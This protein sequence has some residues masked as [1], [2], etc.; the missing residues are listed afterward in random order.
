MLEEAKQCPL[1]SLHDSNSPVVSSSVNCYITT[2]LTPRIKREKKAFSYAWHATVKTLQLV[3]LVSIISMFAAGTVRSALPTTSRTPLYSNQTKDGT[4]H[5]LSRTETHAK[6]CEDTVASLT[7]DFEYNVTD[8][9]A[10]R[11]QWALYDD[12]QFDPERNFRGEIIF[13]RGDVRQTSDIEVHVIISSTQENVLQNVLLNSTKNALSLD[14][15]YPEEDDHCTDLQILVLFRPWPKRLLDVLKVRSEILDIS[16]HGSLSWEVNH[17][18]VHTSHGD[19]D[20][21]GVRSPDPLI[22]HNVSVSTGTGTVFA[23]FIADGHLEVHGESGFVGFFL[24]PRYSW[25]KRPFNPES[26]SVSTVSGNIH[27]EAGFDYWPPH[28]L[29]HTTNIHTLS[30]DVYAYI[31]H[32]SFTNITSVTSSIATY[33]KP[34]GAARSDDRSEIYTSSQSGARTYVYLVDADPESLEG[35]YDPL[36]N[37]TSEH[38]VGEGKLELRYPFSWFGEME[39]QIEHGPLYFDASALEHIERGE[40]YVKAKRGKG[41]ESRMS[42]RV[43]T[44]DLDVRIGLS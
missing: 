40:G 2:T 31:P 41:G 27:V 35:Y 30:G 11:R 7:R 3:L 18:I 25:Q 22:T 1:V 29:A 26:I 19:F 28:P 43:G 10:A 39:A 38:Y 12:V 44:G 6:R 23:Y 42:A 36:I 15:I 13:R 33:L 20:F 14:Y 37:T 9:D 32:G 5:N 16:F 17:L 21:Q 34:Y 4:N 8:A 24:M